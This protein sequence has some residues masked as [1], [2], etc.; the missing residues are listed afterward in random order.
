AF[1]SKA[2]LT[3]EGLGHQLHQEIDI[4]GSFEPHL[5]RLVI[6]R[7]DPGEIARRMRGEW[8]DTMRLVENLPQKV[9]RII[10]HLEKGEISV[11]FEG[12]HRLEKVLVQSSNRLTMGVVLGALIMGSSVMIAARI[13]PLLF[14]LSALGIISFLFSGFVGLRLLLDIRR[15]RK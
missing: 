13:P 11:R 14:G 7:A 6:E 1:M 3:M 2:L 8:A 4:V 12:T 9:H 5:R 10:N 15:E